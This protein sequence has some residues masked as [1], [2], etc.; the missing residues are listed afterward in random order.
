MRTNK[1][2]TMIELM[3]TLMVIAIAARLS[4]PKVEEW[5]ARQQAKQFASQLIADFSKARILAGN[6]YIPDNDSLHLV[7]VGTGTISN[8]SALYFEIKNGKSAYWILSRNSTATGAWTPANDPTVR[9]MELPGRIAITRLNG[10]TFAE[11]STG[12]VAFTSSGRAKTNSN[13]L[14]TL[15]AVSCGGVFSPTASTLRVDFKANVN[16]TTDIFYSVSVNNFG[17]Y[18]VCMSVGNE[19]FASNGLEVKSI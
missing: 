1:A 6:T 13:T 2:F 16:S 17:E 5:I 4:M 12:A 8:Q 15:S 10:M 14:V 3:V 18:Q 7:Q 9:K 19:N 11:G